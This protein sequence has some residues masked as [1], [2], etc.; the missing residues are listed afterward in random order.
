MGHKDVKTKSTV[1]PLSKEVQTKERIFKTR[2]RKNSEAL[3]SKSQVPVPA[4]A[5][6][7]V[8]VLLLCFGHGL[9]AQEACQFAA[10]QTDNGTSPKE[11]GNC[12]PPHQN[13]PTADP[14][15]NSRSPADRPPDD[16]EEDGKGENWQEDWREED[17]ATR[18]NF[19]PR[20]P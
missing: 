17:P 10:T 4:K 18:E 2:C 19:L 11:L 15:S 5:K 6:G 1:T 9:A 16:M 8:N 14:A 7:R 3:S 13:S 12:D 20:S